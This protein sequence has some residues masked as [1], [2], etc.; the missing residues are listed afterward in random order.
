MTHRTSHRTNYNTERSKSMPKSQLPYLILEALESGNWEP[1]ESDK[2]TETFIRDGEQV[3]IGVN[4]LRGT[5]PAS[6]VYEIRDFDNEITKTH[7][8]VMNLLCTRLAKPYK[9]ST[10]FDNVS[11]TK[12]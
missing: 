7:M 11:T 6:F 12:E 9:M 8:L 3:K 1:S 5:N 10:W 4:K 2:N